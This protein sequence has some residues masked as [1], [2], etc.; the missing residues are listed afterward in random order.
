MDTKRS[1]AA[2][3]TQ[4]EDDASPRPARLAATT[5]GPVLRRRRAG[6]G[7]AGLGAPRGAKEARRMRRLPLR[8]VTCVDCGHV[9]N[10]AFDYAH[11]PYAD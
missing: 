1:G 6:T 9:F 3:S 10:A 5:C 4:P 8:F 11:V 7:Q 2:G